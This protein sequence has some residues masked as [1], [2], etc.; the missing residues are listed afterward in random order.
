VKFVGEDG[1]LGGAHVKLECL[2]QQV[3]KFVGEA[4]TLG[5]AHVKLDHLY[6]Q[7]SEICWRG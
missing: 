5:C 1:A 6:Q 7:V 4:K 2:S 3:L